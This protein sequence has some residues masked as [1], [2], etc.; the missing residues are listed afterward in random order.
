M[1][2]LPPMSSLR[3]MEVTLSHMATT[4]DERARQTELD[5]LIREQEDDDN[6]YVEWGEKGHVSFDGETTELGGRKRPIHEVIGYDPETGDVV[7]PRW[8]KP[9]R[10]GYFVQRPSQQ[11]L[12]RHGRSGYVHHGCRCAICRKANQE[13]QRRYH[14]DYRAGRVRRPT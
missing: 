3:K 14:R 6:T 1:L 10:S 12:F 7:T 11:P 4:S 5:R 8:W 13:Y 9:S 2:T